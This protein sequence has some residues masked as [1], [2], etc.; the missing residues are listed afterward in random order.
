ML[1]DKQPEA[2]CVDN[3][4]ENSWD[5]SHK[6]SYAS[7]TSWQL[8]LFHPAD[9]KHSTYLHKSRELAN[10]FLQSVSYINILRLFMNFRFYRDDCLH[11]I[12]WMFYIPSMDSFVLLSADN[13]TILAAIGF[14]FKQILVMI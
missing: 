13:L 7:K 8:G 3:E 4:P 1:T 12:K 11:V 14:S 2:I 9:I 5:C 6:Y 10:Q